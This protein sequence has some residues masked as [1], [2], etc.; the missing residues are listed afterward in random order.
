MPKGLLC[1]IT[2]LRETL[3]DPLNQ[4]LR[5]S[6]RPVGLQLNPLGYLRLS[7]VSLSEVSLGRTNWNYCRAFPA[8]YLN[9]ENM[10]ALKPSPYCY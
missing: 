8:P 6:I 10:M 3:L 1:Y 2:L 7:Q 9:S 5:P 4:K